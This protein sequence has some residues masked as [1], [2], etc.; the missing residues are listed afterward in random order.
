VPGI[1]LSLEKSEYVVEEEID[2]SSRALQLC[3]VGRDILFPVE[4]YLEV[5]NGSAEGE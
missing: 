1:N 5:H 3:A 4:A 2:G